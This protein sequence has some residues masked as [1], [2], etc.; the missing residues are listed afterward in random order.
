M[1]HGFYIPI[2][3]TVI[4]GKPSHCSS[5]KKR[6]LL[7]ILCSVSV[8]FLFTLGIFLNP[9]VCTGQEIASPLLN[10]KDG[11][12][13]L[14]ELITQM[15]DSIENSEKLQ[16]A[17]AVE[18]QSAKK[19]NS[20]MASSTD[21]EMPVEEKHEEEAIAGFESSDSVFVLGKKTEFEGLRMADVGENGVMI[22]IEDNIDPVLYLRFQR[23]MTQEV[24][25]SV[26]TRSGTS[27]FRVQKRNL[28]VG[29]QV[30]LDHSEWPMGT[31]ILRVRTSEGEL[32]KKRIQKTGQFVSN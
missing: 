31:H 17:T 24:Q 16:R 27:L 21:T 3:G 12:E 2:F 6:S 25:V 18:A 13:A 9:Q 28:F 14:R 29:T 15:A 26:H 19:V 30:T 1:F 4:Q 20:S 7:T 22:L 23:L 11:A 5:M 10:K 8:H 32:W